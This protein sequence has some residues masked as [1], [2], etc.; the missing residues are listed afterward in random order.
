MSDSKS[1]EF[2]LLTCA[3]KALVETHP[4]KTAFRNCFL[5]LANAKE[6]KGGG[7]LLQSILKSASTT[8]DD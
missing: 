4:D 3:I 2:E 6:I 1:D 8:S 7:K 5:A